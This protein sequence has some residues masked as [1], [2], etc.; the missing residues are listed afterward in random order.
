VDAR[1]NLGVAAYRQGRRGDAAEAWREV[2]RLD[3]AH[4]AALKWLPQVDS[5]AAAREEEQ[6]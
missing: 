2:L 1:F 6:S 4:P 3:P 5:S